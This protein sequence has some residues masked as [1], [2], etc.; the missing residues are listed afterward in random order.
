MRRYGRFPSGI[1]SSLGSLQNQQS[2]RVARPPFH[3]VSVSFGNETAWALPIRHFVVSVP[4]GTESACALIIRHFLVSVP[5]G[6]D[7]ARA[8]PIRH[9]VVSVP[10]GIE[11]ARALPI[12]HIVVSVPIRNETAWAL[13]IRHFIVS[14]PSGKESAHARWPKSRYPAGTFCV[15]SVS[16]WNTRDTVR[17]SRSD[18][19]IDW[20]DSGRG[21]ETTNQRPPT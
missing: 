6:T 19:L 18:G 14:V 5:S 9:F 2:M 4:F 16:F 15:V 1:L 3:L 13:P 10:I 11:G 8:L 12:R 17:M 20:R 21:T 7:S